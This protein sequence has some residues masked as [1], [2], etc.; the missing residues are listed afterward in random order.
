MAYCAIACGR[1]ALA[2]VLAGAISAADLR[3]A[4]LKVFC[5]TA[6]DPRP[7]APERRCGQMA[8]HK[9]PE[10]SFIQTI[11]M[12]NGF[13]GRAIFPGHFNNTG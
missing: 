12:F 13:E 9:Y 11:Q 1:T 5:D 2:F 10:R 6:T 7:P 3:I 8:A 4:Q